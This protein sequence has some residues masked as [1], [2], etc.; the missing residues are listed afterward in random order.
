MA[1]V[2]I[3]CGSFLIHVFSILKKKI[4]PTQHI[5]NN[6]KPYCVNLPA[7]REPKTTSP[8]LRMC[9]SPVRLANPALSPLCIL[10]APSTLHS[11]SSHSS[12]HLS[13]YQSCL[14]VFLPHVKP[15]PPLKYSAPRLDH[16]RSCRSA[17]YQ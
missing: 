8:P 4:N 10:P 15:N 9:V 11:D 14:H 12:H 1:R 7:S 17:C 16:S 3:G 5:N 2:G 13:E 6:P